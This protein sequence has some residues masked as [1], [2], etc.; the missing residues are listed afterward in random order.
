MRLIYGRI[1]VELATVVALQA[2][3]EAWR[4]THANAIG[5]RHTRL[6]NG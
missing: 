5:H 3:E 1:S 4:L 2:L 6:Y